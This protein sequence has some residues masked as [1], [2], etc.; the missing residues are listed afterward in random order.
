MSK[1]QSEEQPGTLTLGG[2]AREEMEYPDT[3]LLLLRYRG[4]ALFILV[5]Y[6]CWLHWLVAATFHFTVSGEDKTDREMRCLVCSIDVLVDKCIY[7][8]LPI[9]IM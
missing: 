4:L 3:S 9:A 7:L 2:K 8:L 1:R 5:Q 6:Q